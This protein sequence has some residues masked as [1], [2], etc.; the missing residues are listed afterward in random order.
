MKKKP[1]K[2]ADVTI[3]L[4]Q[5][6][7]ELDFD[8]VL[9]LVSSLCIVVRG[10]ALAEQ[11]LGDSFIGHF[12]A[13]VIPI[14]VKINGTEQRVRWCHRRLLLVACGIMQGLITGIGKSRHVLDRAETP[15]VNL[16]RR[17]MSL[18]NKLR[19]NRNNRAIFCRTIDGLLAFGG[20][21]AAQLLLVVLGEVV[22]NDRNGQC[23]DQDATHAA[24]RANQL[25]PHRLGI[26]ISIADGGHGLVVFGGSEREKGQVRLRSNNDVQLLTM[27]AHQNACGIDRN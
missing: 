6:G 12:A 20:L 9:L 27:L 11:S 14:R 25:A 23:N 1:S 19:V 18:G 5:Q 24:H 4:I 16:S 13:V 22:H 15:R 3:H 8:R 21:L 26:D 10:I 2:S 17:R 7:I